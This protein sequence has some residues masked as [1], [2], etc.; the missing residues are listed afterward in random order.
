MGVQVS[1]STGTVKQWFEESA[2]DVYDLDLPYLSEGAVIELEGVPSEYTL[3]VVASN[4]ERD[5]DSYGNSS[6]DGFIVFS[7]T[8][9]DGESD[10]FKLPVSYVSYDGWNIQTNFISPTSKQEKVVTFWE[11]V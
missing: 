3:K 1:I 2:D 11:W 6:A 4:T 5:Y 7:V 10:N 8:G 9:P